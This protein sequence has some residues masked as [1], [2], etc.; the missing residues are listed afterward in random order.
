MTLDDLAELFRKEDLFILASHEPPDADGLGAMYALYRAFLKLGKKTV[1][2]IS[3]PLSKEYAFLDPSGVFSILGESGSP[4]MNIPKDMDISECLLVVLDTNDVHYAGRIAD[5]LLDRVRGHLLI[6]HHEA[7]SIE[8]KNHLLAPGASSTC[9]LAYELI[10]KLHIAIDLDMAN[11]L[12]AGIVYDTGSF[13]YPKTTETTFACALELVRLGV[14]PYNIHNLLYESSSIASL[15]LSKLVLSTLELYSQDRVAVQVM[16]RKHLKQSGATYEE[17]EDLINVPLRS[18]TVLI[19]V[20]FK[21]NSNGVLR[22]SLRSK[23]NVNVA[24]IAQGF[25]GGGHKTAAG[26]K[27][28]LPLEQ[29][30]KSVLDKVM[31]ALP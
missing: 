12:F 10:Q 11:A 7:H 19:S 5:L 4:D 17:S 26:F 8:P 22:C 9:E 18:E 27:C 13:G 20:F 15:L 2:V 25:G 31:D 23:G 6:D 29:T 1:A 16:L 24:H 28:V 3:E 21:E 30:R 14:Q